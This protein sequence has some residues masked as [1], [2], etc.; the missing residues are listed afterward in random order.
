MLPLPAFACRKV[1]SSWFG[2]YFE[3]DKRNTTFFAE[4]RAGLIC[5]LTVAYIIPVSAVHTQCYAHGHADE[6]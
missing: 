1:T 3:C 2:R 6:L 5:F 4:I